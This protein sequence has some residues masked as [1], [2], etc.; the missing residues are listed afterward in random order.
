MVIYAM[1]TRNYDGPHGVLNIYVENDGF[2]D[3]LT[4][5]PASGQEKYGITATLW[6]VIV[7][8]PETYTSFQV[9]SGQIIAFE[10]YEIT[11]LRIDEEG[12]HF[13]EVEVH[14]V[15]EGPGQ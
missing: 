11:I 8:H 3:T 1:L 7:D 4:T 6:L 14:A 12:R 13:V 15:E 5:D 10:G 9:K 2:P